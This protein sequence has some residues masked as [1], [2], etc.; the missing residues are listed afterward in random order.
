MCVF[1]Y[2]MPLTLHVTGSLYIQMKELLAHATTV[3]SL[4][5]LSPKVNDK[6]NVQVSTEV[7]LPPNASGEAMDITESVPVVLEP[8]RVDANLAKNVSTQIFT[9]YFILGCV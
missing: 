5:E 1:S 2:E 4:M 6:K 9:S 7:Y 8:K 3:A